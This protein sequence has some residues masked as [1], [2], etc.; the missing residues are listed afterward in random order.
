MVYVMQKTDEQFSSLNYVS[1]SLKND[2]VLPLPAGALI[3]NK[4]FSIPSAI[5][6][7]P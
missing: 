1:I 3:K 4:L 7:P 6:I 5:L 2:V